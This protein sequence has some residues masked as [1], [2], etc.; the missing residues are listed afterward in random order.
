MVTSVPNPRNRRPGVLV[1]AWIRN[2]WFG[3]RVRLV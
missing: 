2:G 3:V 1:V